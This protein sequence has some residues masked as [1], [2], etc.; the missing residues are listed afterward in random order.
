[1]E[2]GPIEGEV[3]EVSDKPSYTPYRV[4]AKWV[5]ETAGLDEMTS[6]TSDKVHPGTRWKPM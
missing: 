6:P 2:S 4:G 5:G 1:M 3:G